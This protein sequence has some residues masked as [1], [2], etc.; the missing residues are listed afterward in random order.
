MEV[1]GQR[2]VSYP[3]ALA[4]HT[5]ETESSL[6]L[7]S[8]VSLAELMSFCAELTGSLDT[9]CHGWL[10][11]RCHGKR[12]TE[13]VCSLHSEELERTSSLR[14]EQTSPP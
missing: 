10:V 6:T 4:P 11:V 7:A 13:F 3:I 5:F 8:L 9:R 2:Q 12:K 1:R 14:E